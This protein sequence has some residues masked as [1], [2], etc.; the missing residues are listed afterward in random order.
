MVIATLGNLPLLRHNSGVVKSIIMKLGKRVYLDVSYSGYS[1]GVKW[2]SFNPAEVFFFC[3]CLSACSFL[4]CL[5]NNSRMDKLKIIQVC[6]QIY[7]DELYSIYSFGIRESKK[8]WVWVSTFF[9]SNFAALLSPTGNQ[10]W[11]LYT[12]L[13]TAKSSSRDVH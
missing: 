8:K 11:H 13:M 3:F 7:H 10:N 2:V 4:V 1:F 9:D 6:V 12:F 5:C